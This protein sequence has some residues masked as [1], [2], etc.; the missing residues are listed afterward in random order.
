VGNA[1][2][3]R[4]GLA[5]TLPASTD[6]RVGRRWDKKRAHRRGRDHGVTTHHHL[7][8]RPLDRWTQRWPGTV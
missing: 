5:T 2:Q 6:S 3:G 1:Q 7:E 8:K 4:T